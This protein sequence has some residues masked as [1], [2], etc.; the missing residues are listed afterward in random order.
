[1]CAETLAFDTAKDSPSIC[2]LGGNPWYTLRFRAE[3]IEGFKAAGYRVCVIVTDE[4]ESAAD[5]IERRLCPAYALPIR[6]TGV[7]PLG[8]LRI[9]WLYWRLLKEIRPRIILAYGMKPI[10]YGAFA[11]RAVGSIRFF[12]LITGRG[13][14][15][16]TATVARRLI[17]ALVRSLLRMALH[18]NAAVIF[19]NQADSD[20]FV[21]WGLVDKRKTHVVNG[22]GVNLDYFRQASPTQSSLTFLLVSRL[23]EK[24]GIREFVR[25]AEIIRASNPEVRFQLLGSSDRNRS[26]IPMATVLEWHN[27]GL[28]EYLGEVAD[29]RPYLEHCSVFVLPSAYGEGVPRSILEALAVGRAVVTTDTPGCRET[30]IDGGNGF[31]VPPNDPDSLIRVLKRFVAEPRLAQVMGLTSRR[32]AEQKFDVH[33]VNRSMFDIML[34]TVEVI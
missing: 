15:F 6:R 33:L 32:L 7:N 30:V 27:K 5:E 26:A 10:I 17:F 25:A 23:I 4:N 18:S 21:K 16:S 1:M 3:L 19:Q 12:S 34:P 20:D 29:V 9:V 31:L 28:V 22:S 8:D 24:K 13:Q 14:A 11:A 2:L